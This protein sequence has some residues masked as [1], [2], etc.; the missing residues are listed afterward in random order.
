MPS[1]DM[2]QPEPAITVSRNDL[3]VLLNALDEQI[4][5][6]SWAIKQIDPGES[7]D[8][9]MEH[10]AGVMVLDELVAT[11]NRYEWFQPQD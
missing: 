9:E 8:A 2:P 5:N 11:R 4:F 7:D 3:L 1:T 10:S 6:T